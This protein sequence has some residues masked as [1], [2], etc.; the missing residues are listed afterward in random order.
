MVVKNKS[1]DFQKE[2]EI[3]AHSIGAFRLISVFLYIIS[4]FLDVKREV[5][6]KCLIVA[7]GVNFWLLLIIAVDGM[8]IVIE[9]FGFFLVI[10]GF[11]TVHKGSLCTLLEGRN[12][13]KFFEYRYTCD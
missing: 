2:L 4:Y 9:K 10:T 6:E 1:S 7:V 13:F 5:T 3:L 8:E 11:I 12:L